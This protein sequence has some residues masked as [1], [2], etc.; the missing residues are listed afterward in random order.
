MQL[1][2]LQGVLNKLRR[3]SKYP[4]ISGVVVL[5]GF[6]REMTIA[7]NYG[8]GAEL[9]IFAIVLTFYVFFGTQIGNSFESVFISEMAH[10]KK[11]AITQM[12]SAVVVIITTV[13]VLLIILGYVYSTSYLELVYPSLSKNQL[14]LADELLMVFVVSIIATVLTGVFRGS[15]YIKG[16]FSTGL[17]GGSFVSFFVILFVFIFSEEMGIISLAYGYMVGSIVFMLVLFLMVKKDFGF[18]F[19]NSLNSI[20]TSGF[21]WKALTLIIVGEVLFQLNYTAQRSM[22]TGLEEGAVSSLYY[23]M[24]IVQVIVTLVVVP[25]TTVLFPKLKRQFHDNQVAGF[26]ML[27][28]YILYFFIFGVCSSIIIYLLADVIVQLAFVRGEFTIEDAHRTA[29]LMSIL[30]FLVPLMSIS[31]LIKY[32][33]YALGN[34]YAPIY[35]HLITWLVLISI[36]PYLIHEFSE[37]GLG[38]SIV[39]SF[40]VS[41]ILLLVSLLWKSKNARV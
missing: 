36:A 9:D 4:L 41:T 30:V 35:G 2:S 21:I 37:Q 15:L 24:A 25:L 38:L 32:G 22:A 10:K 1:L 12:L 27:N 3:Y 20:R 33:Y 31:R 23:S 6:L 29:S 14:A 26:R 18:D 40:A 5:L 8:L 7:A 17:L 16:K 39:T 28:N 11:A 19:K 34:Y 13:Y